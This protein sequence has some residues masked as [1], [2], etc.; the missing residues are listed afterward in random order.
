MSACLFA[1]P[2]PL[3]TSTRV[4]CVVQQGDTEGEIPSSC[5][6]KAHNILISISWSWMALMI[7]SST[8]ANGDL[9]TQRINMGQ[10]ET[11]L[12]R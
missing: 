12:E 10:S 3:L 5:V 11:K 1:N 7:S 2:I 4:R 6:D 9:E 8:S